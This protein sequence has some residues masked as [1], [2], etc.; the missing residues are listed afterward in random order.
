MSLATKL[1]TFK[2]IQL[3]AIAFYAVTGIILLAF[4]PLTGYPPHL[5][6][7]GIFSL[8]TAYSLFVKRGWAL[9]LVA[10]VFV[11]NTVFSMDTLISTGFINVL[12]AVSM[13]GFAL[14]TWLFTAYLLL[15]RK[16]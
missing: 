2:P 10:V 14:L 6:F 7:L 4:L 11:V 8:I 15:K 9:W 13:V 1:K 3:A 5:G 12:V 16:A